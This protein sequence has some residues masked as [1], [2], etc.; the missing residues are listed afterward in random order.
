MKALL[1][2][3]V[4]AMGACG[5]KDKSGARLDLADARLVITQAD[6]A[7]H[8]LALAAGGAV[9]FD[10]QPVLTLERLGHIVVGGHR[11]ARVEL[12]GSISANKVRTNAT[13]S[14]E[15]TFVLDGQTE[16]TIADDGAVTGP[17]FE[18]MDHP[19]LKLEG[20]KVRYE[21]PPAARRATMVGFA[22]FVTSLPAAVIAK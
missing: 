19:R 12:D 3:G 8:V 13:V 11:L 16:L 15:G 1:V 22:A 20:A 5:A 9:T 7:T 4:L 6:G 18:T 10:N 2:L 21:G 14:P 17:L